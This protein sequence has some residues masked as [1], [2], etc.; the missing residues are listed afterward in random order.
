[1]IFDTVLMQIIGT[2]NKP[3]PFMKNNFDKTSVIRQKGESQNGCFKKTKQAKFSE[4]LTFLTPWYAHV[5]VVMQVHD[6]N[7]SDNK[8]E[9]FQW[10]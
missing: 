8:N 6:S 1:M 4:K 7:E 10:K 5:P 9:S 2:V 3:L